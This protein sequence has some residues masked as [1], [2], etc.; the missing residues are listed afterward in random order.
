[1]VRLTSC[2]NPR[3]ALSCGAT[4]LVHLPA[5][6][7]EVSIRAPHFHAGRRRQAM[8][9]SARWVTFQSAP[10]TFM[11]GDDKGMVAQ[12]SMSEFQSAPRTFMRGD[13]IVRC[14]HSS[15]CVS[16]RAPHF[17]A[18]RP[19]RPAGS[20]AVMVFQSAPRTFMRGDSIVVPPAQ[21]KRVSIR[22]PHFHAGRPRPESF[23]SPSRGF[24]PRPALSCGA[25]RS[26]AKYPRALACFNPRPA[27]SCGATD[28]KRLQCDH[29][30][31]SIR[32]PHFHAG[33]RNC[34]LSLVDAT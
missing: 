11:R 21:E 6:P 26:G 13:C 19:M 22:A 5:Q 30:P 29:E 10:R 23:G 9:C 20:A 28:L 16:I 8:S 4:L 32:A 2:F 24:N 15:I 18:G 12:L 17:H 14:N 27:L 31:V 1:M 25:T 7:T 3:P 34:P 33:R